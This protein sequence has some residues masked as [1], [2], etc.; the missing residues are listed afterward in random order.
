MIMPEFLNLTNP[1][2]GRFG[3]ALRETK[4]RPGHA[5]RARDPTSATSCRTGA[6][7]DGVAAAG[8]LARHHQ[9]D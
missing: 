7:L 2:G 9:W 6:G 1:T 4:P 3:D 8:Q 5:V